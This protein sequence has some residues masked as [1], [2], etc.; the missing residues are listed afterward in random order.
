[1]DNPNQ[2]MLTTLH[3]IL[4]SHFDEEELKTL[5]FDMG[6]DYDDLPTQGR[7]NKARELVKLAVREQRL[8]ELVELAREYRP[9]ADW[10]SDQFLNR[11]TD[12]PILAIETEYFEP[13][14][15]FI[16]PGPFSI[17]SHDS[18][19]VPAH[20]TPQHEFSLPAYRIGRYPVTNTQYAEF[21]KQGRRAERGAERA[22]Q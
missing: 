2:S 16:P 1:M 14:T 15:L 11:L 22:A 5:A 21:L 18:Q 9:K 4:V 17:G 10:P 3:R 8:P 13:E 19:G 20:E 12:D 7:A 6:I